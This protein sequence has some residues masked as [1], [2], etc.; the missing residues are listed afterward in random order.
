MSKILTELQILISIIWIFPV[1][2]KEKEKNM[3]A[4][5][6]FSLEMVTPH[7]Q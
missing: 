2:L 5:F 1:E 7:Y 4:L 3:A 6:I